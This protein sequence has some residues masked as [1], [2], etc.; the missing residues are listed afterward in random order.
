VTSQQRKNKCR[1]K[2]WRGIISKV[3]RKWGEVV[4]CLLAA[5]E[6]RGEWSSELH[7]LSATASATRHHPLYLHTVHP[8][9]V[10]DFVSGP[11]PHYSPTWLRLP[12]SCN[13]KSQ[14]SSNIH[15]RAVLFQQSC[16]TE[17]LGTGTFGAQQ[18]LTAHVQPLAT[19][20]ACLDCSIRGALYVLSFLHLRC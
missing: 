17:L 19:W 9:L 15:R 10:Y 13:P 16:L 7:C 8:T 14:Y 2:Q 11:P 18:P 3:A 4:V 5:D 6:W 12:G 20:E 1:E